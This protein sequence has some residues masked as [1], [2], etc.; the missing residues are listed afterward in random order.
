IAPPNTTPLPSAARGIWVCY[1]PES[2]MNGASDFKVHLASL[3]EGLLVLP[4]EV[5]SRQ[6]FE[7][8]KYSNEATWVQDGP[9]VMDPYPLFQYVSRSLLQICAH[10]FEQLPPEYEGLISPQD[11]LRSLT[12]KVNG[13]R[14]T[15]GEWSA[16]P[17]G[18]AFDSYD[19]EEEAAGDKVD[20]AN[21]LD[22]TTSRRS[23]HNAVVQ[24]RE[25]EIQWLDHCGKHAKF[26]PSMANVNF[27]QYKERIKVGMQG[28]RCLPRGSTVK[29]ME[30]AL[31]QKTKNNQGS[32][33]NKRK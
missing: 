18:A 25:H 6:G 16:A 4:P 27:D 19:T 7:G 20:Q 26:I 33:Q 5:T 13:K 15:A 11:F 10:V 2:M 12:M 28:K 29:K 31:S 14:V 32:S 23:K 1:P 22:A 21:D 8:H 17:D 3:G 24:H 9:N 30:G